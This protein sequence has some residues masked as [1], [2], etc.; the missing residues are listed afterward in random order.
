[1]NARR[2]LLRLAGVALVALSGWAAV[3]A[4]TGDNSSNPSP[5]A[6]TG[7]SGISSGTGGSGSS[8]GTGGSGSSS[9]TGGSGSSSGTGGS[10]SSSGTAGDAG[11]FDASS[12]CNSCTTPDAD[13]Y[14]ACSSQV[15][16]CIPFDDMR[17]PVHMSV[18]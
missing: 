2:N 14:N 7:G 10:G 5:D 12:K 13:P 4:C 15:T 9:G 11:C 1:M 8:S 18:P 6:G 3:V 16:N 17:V